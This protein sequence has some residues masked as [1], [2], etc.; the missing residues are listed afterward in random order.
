MGHEN[1]FD[2]RV[3]DDAAE[4]RTVLHNMLQI[5]IHSAHALPINC[6]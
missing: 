2:E 3:C 5:C 6:I 1:Y 4:L